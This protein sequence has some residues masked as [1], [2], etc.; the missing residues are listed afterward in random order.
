M[1]MTCLTR[2]LLSCLLLLPLSAATAQD[3]EPTTPAQ[4][5]AATRAA[6]EILAEHDGI[7]PPPF[8]PAR[9]EEPDYM[10]EYDAACQVT[11]RRQTLLIHELS[12][13]EPEHEALDVLL[14]KLWART[15]ISEMVIDGYDP[16]QHMQAYLDRFPDKPAAK[17]ARLYLP[18]SRLYRI[19]DLKAPSNKRLR[20][21]AFAEMDT[22]LAMYPEEE[23]GKKLKL[24]WMKF[25]Y[26]RAQET[27]ELAKIYTQISEVAPNTKQARWAAGQLRQIREIGQPFE[28]AHEDLLGGEIVSMD[29]YR[30]KIV[31]V[32]FWA[33][34]SAPCLTQLPRW[35]EV[36]EEYEEHGVVFI[37]VPLNPEAERVREFCSEKDIQWPQ[38]WMGPKARAFTESWGIYGAP[39]IFILDHEGNLASTR[40]KDELKEKIQELLAKRDN[41]DTQPEV[42]E[43]DEAG[44]S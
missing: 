1:H 17:Q 5:T 22:Y 2:C 28:L 14:E 38:L 32:I 40:G 35:V 36:L 42:E 12:Q 44:E 4:P 26:V 20:A 6:E 23:I 24:V 7:E 30:G 25:P 13:V 39:T 16:L 37:G 18:L 21:T 10:A 41:V 8:E 9:M 33:S 19:T 31:A 27:E 34:H 29:D 15:G 43:S 3:A 11:V